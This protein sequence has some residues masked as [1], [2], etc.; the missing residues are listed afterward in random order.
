[1]TATG[2][3]HPSEQALRVRRG[4]GASPGFLVQLED[5]GTGA[6]FQEVRSPLVLLQIGE[7]GRVPPSCAPGAVSQATVAGHPVSS[8][9]APSARPWTS[10]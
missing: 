5:Q 9:R 3:A 4:G 1:M 2:A 6:R 7:R 10:P 8:A